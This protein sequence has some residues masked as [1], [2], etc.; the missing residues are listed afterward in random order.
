LN[1]CV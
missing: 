1:R